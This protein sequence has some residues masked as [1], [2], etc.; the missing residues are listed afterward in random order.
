MTFNFCGMVCH[1]P[2]GNIVKAALGVSA[3]MPALRKVSQ[4]L[5]HKANLGCSRCTFKAEREHDTTGASGKMSFLTL[6]V[7]PIRMR[8]DVLAQAEEYQK[9]SSK[10]QAKIIQKNNG[11]RY[12][13]ATMF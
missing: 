11:V 13:Q 2:N 6:K 10:V 12:A 7:A 5:G 3:D 4:I 9:S 8:D 1:G